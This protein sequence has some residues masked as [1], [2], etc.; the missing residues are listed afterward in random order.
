MVGFKTETVLWGRHDKKK[1]LSY[2]DIFVK[3]ESKYL[4]KNRERLYI[5]YY[6]YIFT[7]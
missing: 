3:T 7:Q 2:V 1:I 6:I 5:M 4:N